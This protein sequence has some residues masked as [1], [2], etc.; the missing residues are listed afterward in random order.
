TPDIEEN[1]MANALGGS[2][3]D[4][5]G[6][7]NVFETNGVNDAVL[8]VNEDIED[9]T[10]LS[11][12]PDADG[13]LASGG[14]LDYR[15]MFDVNPPIIATI[16]F[17]GVD[18]Y[19]SGEALLQGLGE[20]SIMAWVKLESKAGVTDR[21]I[22]GEDVSCRLYRKHGNT[23]SFGI[24]TASGATNVINGISISDNEWH[25]VAG[26]F[27]SATG[28]QTIYVDGKMISTVTN[29]SLVGETILADSSLWNGN[30]EVGR[31]SREASP[32][33]QYF[34]GNIDEVRVYD[35]ALTTDQIQTQVYQEITNNSGQVQGT[36]IPKDIIDFSTQTKVPWSNLIGYYPMTS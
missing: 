36:V 25:H 30:F 17:D 32:T 27:S 13:D 21:T 4:T 28:T 19:L 34:S 11:I 18:D 33:I 7:D 29:G 14:D 22:V 9:P 6:L 24:R 1:G 26:T 23:L 15:D 2:D 12:L 5:D 20:L 3:T 16:D 8:D 10:D 35:I 31:L